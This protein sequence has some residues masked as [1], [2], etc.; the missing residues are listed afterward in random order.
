M[1]DSGGPWQAATTRERPGDLRHERP[2]A[3]DSAQSPTSRAADNGSR[4]IPAVDPGQ[5]RSVSRVPQSH[6]RHPAM[7]RV[8]LR[9][10]SGGQPAVHATKPG[11]SFSRTRTLAMRDSV[12]RSSHR[13]V[14][15]D[16]LGRRT[17]FNWR[18]VQVSEGF[19]ARCSPIGRFAPLRH[20][21]GTARRPRKAPQSCQDRCRPH[22]PGRFSEIPPG[23]GHCERGSQRS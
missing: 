10:Y 16:A 9:R 1:A 17:V 11:F 18:A 6:G 3:T 7:A 4:S 8:N 12:S 13:N 2:R 14:M 5:R 15:Q 23:R 22:G 21:V 19:R 20:A